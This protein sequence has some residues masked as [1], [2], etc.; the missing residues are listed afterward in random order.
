[1]EQETS[2]IDVQAERDRIDILEV[3]CS[4]LLKHVSVLESTIARLEQDLIRER[5]HTSNQT[6]EIEMLAKKSTRRKLKFKLL[7]QSTNDRKNIEWGND[8]ESTS[9]DEASV[10]D[11]ELASLSTSK[12]KPRWNIGVRT[13]LLNQ[14]APNSVFY[15][16]SDDEIQ[17]TCS[18]KTSMSTTRTTKDMDNASEECV[19]ILHNL[20]QS[21]Q[22]RRASKLMVQHAISTLLTFQKKLQVQEKIRTPGVDAKE[23]SITPADISETRKIHAWSTIQKP[24]SQVKDT[25]FITQRPPKTFAK[26]MIKLRERGQR[27]RRQMEPSTQKIEG[28]QGIRLG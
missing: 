22:T 26:E 6:K 25:F 10:I 12:S 28:I 9:E 8:S 18:R 14:Q 23:A 16:S 7:R 11:A 1:M 21:I 24:N 27:V 15:P 3:D 19:K 2:K 17:S 4:N 20:L 13:D 5:L